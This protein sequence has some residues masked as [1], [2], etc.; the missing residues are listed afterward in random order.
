MLRP[1]IFVGCGGSGQ[2]AVRY[3][4][5]AVRRHLEHSGW[6]KGMPKAW[7]FLAIDTLTDQEDPSIPF[8]PN[9]DYVS[10]S[11]AFKDFQG[12]NAALMAKF[13]PKI[14]PAGYRDLMGWRP[15][16]DHVAV[17]LQDG[18][19]QIRA[20]GRTAGVLALQDSVKVRMRQAFEKCTAGGP[21]LGEVSRHLGVNVPPGTPIPSPIT[22]I[23]GS[24]AG[25]TG[26][27]I[28]LDVVDLMRRTHLDGKFPVMVAFTPDIFGDNQPAMT[29]NSAAFMSE[30][31]SAYWDDEASDSALIPTDVPVHTRGPHSVFI[32]GR[33]NIDGLDLADS[34]N[35]Y[36]A[37]G[38]ALSA[39]VFSADVQKEFHNFITV[40]WIARAPENQGGYGFNPE[41]LKGVASSFGS[42]TV[43]I[44][45][46]RFRDYLQK[47]L[48]RSV[49]DHLDTGFEKVASAKLG[50]EAKNLAGHA[51][52]AELSRR[53][54]D[55][56]MVA[57]GLHEVAG[58]QRQITNSF[59]SDEV[60]KAQGRDVADKIRAPFSGVPQQSAQQWQARVASQAQAI[61]A[62][63]IAEIEAEISAS[64]RT[65]GTKT[66]E[67]VLLATTQFSCDLSYP[68]TIDL[69]VQ[70][71]SMV[72][73]SADLLKEESKQFR[74][75]G[76]EQYNSASASLAQS[77]KGN[78]ALSADPIRLMIESYSNAIVRE[79]AAVVKEKLA[80]A[81]ESVAVNML[82][83]IEASIRQSQARI[84]TLTTPQDGKPAVIAEWP[85][86]EKVVPPSFAPSPVEFFLEEYTTWPQ[87][88]EDLIEL[89]LDSRENLSEKA[90]PAARS[91]I[92][93]GGFGGNG[94][95]VAD[96]RP[97]IW[98]DSKGGRVVWE[99]GQLVSIKIN[100][101]FE[102]LS[103]RINGWMMRPSTELS[104][105]LSEG[106]K[107]YLKPINPR[108]NMAV[109]D[110][111]D[112]LSS[113]RQKLQLALMQS[114]PLM[115]IDQTMYSTV[116]SMKISYE[117]NISGFPFG[118]GHPA[119]E[120]TKE[121]VMGF[122]NDG[123]PVDK[124]F[125]S[126]DPESVLI[127]NFLKH[128][129][130]PSV[131]TSFTQPLS[132]VLNKMSKE[133]LRSSFWQ[134]RRAR[135]LENFVP[136]PDELR[137]AAIRGFAVAR[138]LGTMTAEVKKQN[139]ISNEGGV[140]N[141]PE[142]LLTETDVKNLLPALLEAMILSFADAPTKGQSAF[143]A[144]GALIGF[145]MG[146]GTSDYSVEG[147][148]HDVLT[149]GAYG[150]VEI[151][152][153]KRADSLL[154]KS[155]PIERADAAIAY[156]N[157]NLEHIDKIDSL[158]LDP[159]SFRNDVGSVTPTDTLS[160]ELAG[161]IRKAYVQVREA[162][163]EFKTAVLD[164]DLI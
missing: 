124:Y 69:L 35:V 66:L 107:D 88:A 116:H 89:S 79:W 158:P 51:K 77:G 97:L 163:K 18:A 135:I 102:E 82:A 95:D 8:L 37:V 53:S 7:Q 110:H 111:Q 61:K 91:Q 137:I 98:V 152:D 62:A 56:F 42:A 138:I 105:A 44:G 93:K 140:H 127:T 64:L 39:V 50:E 112:R 4:R 45:R 113:F 80:V 87:R 162:L 27:G 48:H 106:L 84:Q 49:I 129:V 10:V 145:G 125:T 143:N 15:N 149:D 117:L 71:R 43:S 5:D 86:D 150:Q 83:P 154:S 120:E 81:L 70:S 90:I 108:T 3:V 47:L 151:L 24:M 34:K 122:L 128:P 159:K 101:G 28:M 17:P 133:K 161:D 57:C 119:R 155:S 78:L 29:A 114:R 144:Y 60:L 164:D 22:I 36:R 126:S 131:I 2:K 14:D 23:L 130:N 12:L 31:M 104:Y 63:K 134:W 68:V 76:S 75:K 123:L 118:E 11:L 85:T 54:I 139:Q 92:I 103:E 40:N 46:D 16:P 6:E 1:V 74:A 141:F 58:G 100:D 121:I 132:S 142:H 30:M 65:W 20:V 13:G 19:G 156:L 153:Q 99:P 73:Q 52:I 148:F 146:G 33:R 9:S 109:T 72:L 26:A 59:M 160:R 25:G 96:V 38:E 136:L 115:E 21:E 94:K 67:N 41:R 147:L 55:Q 32:V 157:K